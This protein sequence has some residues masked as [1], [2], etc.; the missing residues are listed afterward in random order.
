M[1]VSPNINCRRARRLSNSTG[2]SLTAD[3]GKYLGVPLLQSILCKLH[4]NPIVEKVQRRLAGWKANVLNLAGRATL[5]QSVT[6]TIP[7]YTMQTMEIPVSVCDNLDRI[8]RNFLRGDTDS[9]KKIHLVNWTTVCK[10]KIGV[11]LASGKL[12]TKTW[13]S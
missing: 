10:S 6:S 5:V 12:E 11:D 4:F 1:Y 3:L 2:I 8:N 7:N 9:T 13:H